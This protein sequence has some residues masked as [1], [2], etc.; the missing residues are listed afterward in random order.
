MTH[1]CPGPKAWAVQI[2]EAS[3]LGKEQ[4]L[5]GY[6]LMCFPF[7]FLYLQEKSR[8]LEMRK[9]FSAWGE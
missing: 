5:H 1:Q 8:V 9:L 2:I 6:L 7:P 3:K 4:A